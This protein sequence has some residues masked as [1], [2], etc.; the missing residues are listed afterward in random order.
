MQYLLTPPFSF[1]ER[2]GFI[3]GGSK[4]AGEQNADQHQTG[5]KDP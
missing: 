5:K 2:W 4:T 3:F 1:T